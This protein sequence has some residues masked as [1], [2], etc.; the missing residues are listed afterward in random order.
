MESVTSLLQK[1]MT[2]REGGRDGVRGDSGR[3]EGRRGMVG[4]GRVGRG[5][6]ENGGRESRKEKVWGRK[7]G[8]GG[9]RKSEQR[10]VCTSL[11]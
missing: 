9:E 3:R 4:R 6:R 5:V 1:V 2:M 8:G 7:G 10:Q 11:Q